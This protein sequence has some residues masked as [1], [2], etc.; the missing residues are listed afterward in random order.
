ADEVG[1][2]KTIEACLIVQ[3]LLAVGKARRV[4]I[5]VPESLT[6]QWF[7]ELLRRFNLWFS[8][9]D[10]ARC[11][12]LEESDP[13]EN[14]FEASQLALCSV[15]FLAADERRREQAVAAGWDMVV[16][17]EAHHLAW[18][19]EG[20]SAEYQLVEQLARR[21]P[22]LLLLTATPTQLG[23][24][25][26]FARL[27]LL[28]PNRYDDFETFVREAE[29][30]GAVAEIA[31]KI[32]EGK[33]LRPKDHATLKRIFNKDPE[34]LA[35]HLDALANGRSEARAALL[36]TLLDQHGTGRVVFRNTRAAMSGFPKRKFCPAPLVDNN[37]ALHA[38]IARELLAEETGADA[39]IR[40][41]FRDDPRIEWLAAFLKRHRPAKVLLI[42]KSQR[43][44]MAI[45][46]A[47]K[48]R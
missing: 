46:A 29:S 22:G 15:G 34:G 16:V 42:C 39:E 26:H 8:I 6:H 30:Y 37:V 27:R 25:G 47:L 7:V 35:Q 32:V 18:S 44:V 1:L 13:G 48:E 3:R 17:D 41:S 9:Y 24:A 14:P 45:E 10:E 19:P 20:A 36:K 5:L 28:D 38:R 43:K 31:E 21:T 2:G 12:A 33:P 23:L 40:H 4:L 11:A